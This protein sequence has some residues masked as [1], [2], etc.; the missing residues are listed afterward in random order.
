MLVLNSEGKIIIYGNL[1]SPL[2]FFLVSVFTLYDGHMVISTPPS[3]LCLWHSAN[4]IKL[5][6]GTWWGPVWDKGLF[7][8][9]NHI[10]SFPSRILLLSSTPFLVTTAHQLP[11]PHPI[12]SILC[13]MDALHGAQNEHHSYLLKRTVVYRHRLFT[14]HNKP[15]HSFL[16]SKS[17]WALVLLSPNFQ[18]P[19]FFFKQWIYT[20]IQL[21]QN[22]IFNYPFSPY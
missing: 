7:W 11:P 14:V 1:F 19:F 20:E 17:F 6:S 15:R 21:T 22:K 3:R 10:A 5:V 2:K 18:L 12:T 4:Q 8:T 9:V 13:H 16:A